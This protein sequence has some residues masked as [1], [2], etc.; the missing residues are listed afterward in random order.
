MQTLKKLFES[1]SREQLEGFYREVKNLQQIML[2]QS[3][4]LEAAMQMFQAT[5][6]ANDMLPEDVKASIS[7]KK[8]CAHCC[9]IRVECG[10]LE[11]K[12]VVDYAKENN[13]QIDME[14]LEHQK[15]LDITEYMFS[16][17]KRCVFLAD[18][19]TCK[20]YPVRP[21]ACRNW[22]VVSDPKDCDT[23]V[24]PHG[25]VMSYSNMDATLPAV[26][27]IGDIMPDGFPK[28]LL[29]YLKTM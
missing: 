15:D 17:H 14:R 20:I 13:I 2:L 29:K 9:H 27:I 21:M 11:A 4:P 3:T 22:F 6:A 26:A 12:V 5:D 8:G 28:L 7:C 10:H 1:Y 25:G 16:P 18:D 19:N 24:N 23:N